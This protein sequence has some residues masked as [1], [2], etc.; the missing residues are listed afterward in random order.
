[1][2]TVEDGTGVVDANS[3][4][5]ALWADT[6]FADRGN[7]SWAAALLAEKETALIQAT[8]Y[9]DV[10]YSYPG[11]RKSSTQALEWPRAGATNH[12]GEMLEG[13]PVIL[14]RA[15]AEL[16]VRALSGELLQDMD[17]V[18]LI[19]RERIEGA[20]EIEYGGDGAYS[21]RVFTFIDK[22]LTSFGIAEKKSGSFGQMRIIRV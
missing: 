7:S 10:I 21:S 22:L 8:D 12:Y 13:V 11:R 5:T 9:L 6:Y 2:F 14:M 20:V 3:Y 4:T 19:K 15:T 1:M 17:K 16:A 18:G